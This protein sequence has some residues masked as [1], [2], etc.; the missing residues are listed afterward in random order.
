M[1]PIEGKWSIDKLAKAQHPG[2]S[3]MSNIK[4]PINKGRALDLT[5][6]LLNKATPGETILD[7]GCRAGAYMDVMS[8]YG[9]MPY[10]IDIIEEYV[11]YCQSKGKF[12][13]YGDATMVHNYFEPHSFDYV[14]GSHIIEHFEEPS[15]ALH[16]LRIVVKEGGLCLLIFPLESKTHGKHKSYFNSVKDFLK[17]VPP[18]WKLDNEFS[19]PHIGKVRLIAIGEI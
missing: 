16:N 9:L 6:H 8:F 11:Q 5:E 12:A 14:W 1:N 4:N 2:V 7:L 18:S 13:V 10:G 17:I 19:G 3:L 15:V